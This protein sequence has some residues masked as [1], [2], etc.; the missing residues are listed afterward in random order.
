MSAFRKFLKSDFMTALAGGAKTGAPALAP[1]GGPPTA[2]AAP[3]DGS[4]GAAQ[5]GAAIGGPNAPAS[6]STDL[7]FDWNSAELTA[8]AKKSLDAY[9]K[10]YLAAKSSDSIAVDAYASTDGKETH[11]QKLSDRR[12]KSV[13]DYLIQQSVPKDKVKAKGHGETDTFSK[14]DFSQN[15]RATLKPPPPSPSPSSGK[16]GMRDA[17]PLTGDKDKKPDLTVKRDPNP[18]IPRPKPPETV[19]RAVVE[20]ELTKWLQA[21]G[22]S[23]GHKGGVV[24][25]TKTVRDAELRLHGNYP[26]GEPDNREPVTPPDGE[27]IGHEADKVAQKI[28]Q[29]LPDPVSKKNFDLFKKLKPEDVKLPPT[30]VTGQLNKKYHEIRDKL[31]GKLPKKIQPYVKKAID[32]LIEKGR[33]YALDKVINEVGVP[34]DLKDEVKKALEDYLKK[35]TD[36]ESEKK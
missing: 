33:D 3:G 5:G 18:P 16:L 12:A 9:A 30:T 29:N 22:K 24:V 17:K 19:K 10:A 11:N 28:V 2:K 8:S 14:D 6:T 35:I 15:R 4:G 1:G 25:A 13:E 26:G 7:F 32:K 27:T 34:A 21:L 23:Q 20:Q 36:D 31:V